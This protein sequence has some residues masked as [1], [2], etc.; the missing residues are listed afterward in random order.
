MYYFYD[1]ETGNSWEEELHECKLIKIYHTNDTAYVQPEDVWY[2]LINSNK[3]FIDHCYE[4][5]F[6][7]KESWGS[8]LSIYNFLEGGSQGIT[9]LKNSGSYELK[10]SFPEQS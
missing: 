8:Y 4:D 1:E 6:F 2:S 9:N 10:M 5:K 7:Y 3:C